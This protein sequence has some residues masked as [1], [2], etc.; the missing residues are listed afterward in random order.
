[1]DNSFHQQDSDMQPMNGFMSR[2]KIIKNKFNWLTGLIV[3]TEEEKKEAGIFLGR[4]GD[5]E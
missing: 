5:R 3:L 4:P 2:L 1:M